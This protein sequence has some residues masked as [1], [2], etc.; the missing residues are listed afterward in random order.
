MADRRARPQPVQHEQL[1]RRGVRAAMLQVVRQ[2]GPHL[3]AQRQQRAVNGLAGTHPDGG[4][5]PVEALQESPLG[6]RA[7]VKESQLPLSKQPPICMVNQQIVIVAK[8]PN[9]PRTFADSLK[10]D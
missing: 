7:S 5:P 2:R 10:H 9:Y 4:V 1:P 3:G 8:M 6:G